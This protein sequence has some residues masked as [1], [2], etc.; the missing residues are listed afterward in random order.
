MRTGFVCPYCP[1]Q[2]LEDPPEL[3]GILVCPTCKLR[4]PLPVMKQLAELRALTT[5]SAELMRKRREKVAEL[6]KQLDGCGSPK[7]LV[8]IGTSEDSECA[9]TVGPI[10]EALRVRSEQLG[11][12]MGTTPVAQTEDDV[13]H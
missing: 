10:I 5:Y 6:D 13:P 4:G 7:C 11:V 1:Q 9:C 12:Y 8:Q 2:M 3:D